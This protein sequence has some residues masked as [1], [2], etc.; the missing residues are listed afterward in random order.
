MG[1]F[2]P[3]M[4]L[5]LGDLIS[6]GASGAGITAQAGA[7]GSGN[8]ATRSVAAS[9]AAATR[10]PNAPAGTSNAGSVAIIINLL[11]TLAGAAA[12]A[13][14]GAGGAWT[15]YFLGNASG[16]DNVRPPAEISEGDLNTASDWVRNLG[17]ILPSIVDGASL[18]A[19][20][21][22][23][24]ADLANAQADYNAAKTFIT[25]YLTRVG[26]AITQAR[27]ALRAAQATPPADT[28]LPPPQY[29]PQPY[30][31]NPGNSGSSSS[32]ASVY[33]IPIGAL[34]IG[35]VLYFMKR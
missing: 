14:G 11:M 16:A 31:P 15:A 3:R 18:A 2:T 24:G 6:V 27:T 7:T 1:K 10:A 13:A 20:A 34:A 9:L 30:V 8:A 25:S 23:T 26:A 35:A 22:K 12:R 28:S 33:L 17:S 5:A 32:D 19:T 21:G 29:I 4:S